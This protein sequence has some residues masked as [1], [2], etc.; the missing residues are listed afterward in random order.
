MKKIIGLSALAVLLLPMLGF[1][2]GA[3]SFRL[4]YYWPRAKSDLWNIEFQNMTFDKRDFETVT[5]G[6]SYEYFMTREV[7]LVFAA[8]FYSR[9]RFGIYRDW[10]GYNIDGFDYA[11]PFKYYD[12]DFDISHSFRTSIVPLQASIKLMPFGRRAAIIP[13]IG[14]GVS[15]FLWSVDLHGDMV[16]FTDQYV[17]A[18]PDLGDVDI[19]GVYPTDA[20]QETKLTVGFHAFAGITIPIARRVAIEAEFKYF[21][22]KGGFS[23]SDSD[24]GDFTGFAGFQSF[25]LGGYQASVGINFWF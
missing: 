16:D 8:D 24:R 13:Y 20:R 22:G 5:F 7:S 1:S 21:Y 9:E 14:G 10:V 3:F 17:Y 19:Y 18:D 11:F 23:A 4:G 2:D 15:F 12:G 6:L 25:D